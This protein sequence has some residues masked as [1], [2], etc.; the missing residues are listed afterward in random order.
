MVAWQNERGAGGCLSF[1]K[2]N[3]IVS[4]LFAFSWSYFQSSSLLCQICRFG[5]RSLCRHYVLEYMICATECHQ[6]KIGA[7]RSGWIG[8][9]K[10]VACTAQRELGLAAPL[11]APHKIPTQRPDRQHHCITARPTDE[12][13]LPVSKWME[14]HEIMTEQKLRVCVSLKEVDTSLR[15]ATWPNWHLTE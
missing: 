11:V 2:L 4:V 15:G 5:E 7:D 14:W 3:S 9:V 12:P 6:Q 10:E 13:H 8:Y 1:E